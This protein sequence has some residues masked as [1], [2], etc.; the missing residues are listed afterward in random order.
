M[1]LI[2]TLNF[3]KIANNPENIYVF[4]F[5]NKVFF[6]IPFSLPET[7]LSDKVLT[8]H[9]ENGRAISPRS[10]SLLSFNLRLSCGSVLQ[11]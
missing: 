10:L 3:N 5:I 11:N 1:P 9:L 8:C 6:I 4:Y 2:P 7:I